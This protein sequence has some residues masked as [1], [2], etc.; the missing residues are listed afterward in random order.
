MVQ[1]QILSG[2]H[3]G[4][5]AVARHFPFAV[6]RDKAADLRLEEEGIWDQHLE[7]KLQ[8]PEGFTLTVH[9]RARA[10][11]NDEPVQHAPLRNG[12]LLA[13]GTVKIRFALSETRQSSLRAREFLT[14]AALAALCA[15]QI[16]MIYRLLP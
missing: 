3:A 4:A 7:I 9:P 13:A 12:D 14:W 1:L 15:G 10:T 11:V 8:M 5:V 2:K 6:G 16:A